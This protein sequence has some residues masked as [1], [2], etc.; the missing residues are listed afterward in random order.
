MKVTYGL[1]TS[2]CMSSHS[3]KW[4]KEQPFTVNHTSCVSQIWK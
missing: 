3:S 1:N 4:R 2:G